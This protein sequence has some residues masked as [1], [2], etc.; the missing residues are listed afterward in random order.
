MKFHAFSFIPVVAFAVM[1][2]YAQDPEPKSDSTGGTPKKEGEVLRATASGETKVIQPVGGNPISGGV[3]EGKAKLAGGA[4]PATFGAL[5][6]HGGPSASTHSF[7]SVMVTKDREG[8]PVTRTV[9][10]SPDG[11]V[12]VDGKATVGAGEPDRTSTGGWMGVRS[13]SVS[14]ALRAHVELPASQGVILEV[15]APNGPAAKAGLAL[16]DILLS[17]DGEPVKGVEDFRTRLNSTRPAQQIRFAYLRRGKQFQ[18]DI[19]IGSPPQQPGNPSPGSQ[20]EAGRIL[21]EMQERIS[22]ANGETVIVG[23]DG[24][25][26][27]NQSTDAFDPFLNDPKVPEAMKEQIRKAREAMKPKA[28]QK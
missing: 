6:V 2:L 18:T 3:V 17:M 5:S 11:K 21:R 13:A 9:T 28:E 8:R 26:V 19:T 27:A 20:T 25:A 15:I 14:D 10:I 23:P 12:T 7:R 1:A 24:K 4:V 22:G 16:Y